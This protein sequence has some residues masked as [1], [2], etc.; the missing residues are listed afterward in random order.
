M[1]SS[2]ADSDEVGEA[3][4]HCGGR[5]QLRRPRRGWVGEEEE[6]EESLLA[7][8]KRIESRVRQ[9]GF[10]VYRDGRDGVPTTVVGSVYEEQEGDGSSKRK[11]KK[12]K[13]RCWRRGKGWNV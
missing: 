4:F 1:T 9:G 8:R 10:Q 11:K 3:G 2:A 7:S 12:K 13:S 5:E 6:D